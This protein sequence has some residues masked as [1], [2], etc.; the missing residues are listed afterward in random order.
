MLFPMGE[1]SPFFAASRLARPRTTVSLI[2]SITYH[3]PMIWI[4]TCLDSLVSPLCRHRQ[5]NECPSCEHWV[6]RSKWRYP[7]GCTL[8][9]TFFPDGTVPAFSL[10]HTENRT[11]ECPP[12]FI[13]RKT[14]AKRTQTGGEATKPVIRI[15]GASIWHGTSSYHTKATLSTTPDATFPAIA[16]KWRR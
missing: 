16:G 5:E 10:N 15:A 13:K 12:C 6:A 9:S 4:L 11:I 2:G 14:S 3:I 7:C 1:Q 8:Y